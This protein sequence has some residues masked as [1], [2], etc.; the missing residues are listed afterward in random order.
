MSEQLLSC[1]PFALCLI[2]RRPPG[3]VVAALWAQDAD[4]VRE[5]DGTLAAR[6]E[7]A[8]R[9]LLALGYR[10][11][12]Y[13]GIENGDVRPLR[14]WAARSSGQF[15]GVAL[16]CFTEEHAAVVRDGR[17]FDTI[18]PP[19]APGDAHPEGDELVRAV[20]CIARGAPP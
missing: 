11:F 12:R 8:R 17:I 19:G 16:L 7:G 15:P 1:V 14:T 2:T 4:C 9:A 13:N 18:C 20:Y 6:P 3:E 5:E 10:V